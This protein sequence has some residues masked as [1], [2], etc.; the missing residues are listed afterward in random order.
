MRVPLYPF[1]TPQRDYSDVARRYTH[2]S[3]C[4]D[5]VKLAFK[6]PEVRKR[7]DARAAGLAGAGVIG[8]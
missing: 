7:N 2:L 4:P 5:F 8:A 3:I 6:W 1:A